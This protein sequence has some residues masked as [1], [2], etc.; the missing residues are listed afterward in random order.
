MTTEACLHDAIDDDLNCKYC[1]STLSQEQILK[2]LTKELQTTKEELS[3]EIAKKE[4][5]ATINEKVKNLKNTIANTETICKQYA[6]NENQQ[7]RLE[8]ANLID[9]AKQEAITSS[10]T[11]LELAKNDLNSVIDEKLD[12]QTFNLKVTNLTQAINNAEI[13]CKAYAD[14]KDS[15]LK[16]QLQNEINESKTALQNANNEIN[17]R[18]NKAENN[19]DKNTKTIHSLKIAL[20]VISIIFAILLPL[21]FVVFY[22][23]FIKK[24]N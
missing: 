3:Q 24:R 15:A 17:K 22:A 7:A 4:D 18:L 20:I 5:V 8:L 16:T 19:I 11:A 1:G 6:D 12:I 2:I 13:A 21:S 10:S 14:S 23:L 9:S